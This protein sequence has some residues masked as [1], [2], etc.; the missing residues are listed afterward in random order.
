M[1]PADTLE[2]AQVAN[3]KGNGTT[4]FAIS[5]WTAH[6][7]AK[8]MLYNAGKEGQ[9][10]NEKF[11]QFESN[12]KMIGIY[13]LDCICLSPWLVQKCN[14]NTKSQQLAMSLLQGAPILGTTNFTNHSITSLVAKIL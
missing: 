9:A 14:C 10:Y 5:S 11:K 1:T 12:L 8:A 4:K 3:I 13:I 6:F 7:N 2:D